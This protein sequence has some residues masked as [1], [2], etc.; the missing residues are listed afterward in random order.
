MIEPT[1][2]VCVCKKC[3]GRNV[4]L[5]MWCDP[6]AYEIIGAWSDDWRGGLGYTYCEDCGEDTGID[7]TPDEE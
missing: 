4:Q 3:G 2:Q 7:T 1:K 6:N 5:A